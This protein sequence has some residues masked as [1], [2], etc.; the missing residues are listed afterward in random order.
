M[1]TTSTVIQGKSS[2]LPVSADA[3]LGPNG[4]FICPACTTHFHHEDFFIAH[5][6]QCHVWMLRGGTR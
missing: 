2:G 1:T 5:V 6:A 3:I 4:G